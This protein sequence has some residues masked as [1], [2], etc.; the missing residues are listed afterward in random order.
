MLD[1]KNIPSRMPPDKGIFEDDFPFPQVGYVS[2]LE[3]K[4]TP[5][6]IGRNDLETSHLLD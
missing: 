3:G 4:S 5:W 1:L 6:R 2:S